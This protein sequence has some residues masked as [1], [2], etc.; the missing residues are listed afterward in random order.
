MLTTDEEMGRYSAQL[1]LLIFVIKKMQIY[2]IYLISEIKYGAPQGIL[3]PII[4]ALYMYPNIIILILIL[5]IKRIY[6]IEF[7]DSGNLN[8]HDCCTH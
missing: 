1:V 7:W 4:L 3:V 6:F 5:I 8:V 2:V